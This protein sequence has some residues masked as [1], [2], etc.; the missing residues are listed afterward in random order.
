MKATQVFLILALMV[1]LSHEGLASIE[2]RSKDK[3]RPTVLRLGD[4]CNPKKCQ[5]DCIRL[6]GSHGNCI[7]GPACNCVFCGPSGPAPASPTLQ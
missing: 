1:L 3:C 2:S 7:E 5:N 4:K 6:G